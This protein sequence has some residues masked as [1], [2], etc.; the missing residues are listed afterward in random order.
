MQDEF[1]LLPDRLHTGNR[2]TLLVFFDPYHHASIQLYIH[3]TFTHPK[4]HMSLSVSTLVYL[5]L[6][7]S[8][9]LPLYNR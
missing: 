4:L 8:V 9:L 6:S 2:E 5:N 7:Y 3:F 1:L